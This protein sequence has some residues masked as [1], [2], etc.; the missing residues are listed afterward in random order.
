MCLG[1]LSLISDRSL[2]SWS[3]EIIRKAHL[4]LE[5]RFVSDE[6]AAQQTKYLANPSLDSTAESLVERLC[7]FK[8][9]ALSVLGYL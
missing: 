8:M 6:I 4:G 5:S 2:Y 7:E 1:S 3:V 9:Y